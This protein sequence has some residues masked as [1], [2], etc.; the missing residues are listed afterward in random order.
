MS[1]H[2][3]ENN[4]DVSLMAMDQYMRFVRWTPELTPEEEKCLLERV[5]R[6]RQEQRKSVPNHQVLEE[7]RQARDRLVEG[8][9]A[10]VIYIANQYKR[11]V[12]SMAHHSRKGKAVCGIR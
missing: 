3:D 9:Q 4:Q 6:G 10:L 12:R 2:D 8:L 5:E 11:R 7:A 1:F